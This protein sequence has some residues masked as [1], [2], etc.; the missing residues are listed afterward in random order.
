[1]SQIQEEFSQVFSSQIHRAGS[2]ELLNWLG[3]KDFSRRRPAPNITVPVK[4]GLPC[5]A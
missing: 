5:T 3:Q 2:E 1:M 4:V